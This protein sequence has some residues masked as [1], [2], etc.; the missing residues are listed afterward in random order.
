MTSRLPAAMAILAAI[1]TVASC[2]TSSGILLDLVQN[3]EGVDESTEPPDPPEEL[4]GLEIRTDPEGASVWINNRYQGTTP[5]VIDELPSGTYRVLITHDG[6][7]EQLVWLDYPGGPMRFQVTLDPVMG[8]VQIDVSPRDADVTL[9]GRR[10]SHG[11]SPV[12]IGSYDV[13]VS[14]FGYAQWNGRI[15]VWE[16]VVS[17]ISVDLEPSPFEILPPVLTR[18]VVNPEN[19]GLLGSVELRFDVTGPGSGTATIF[20][21]QGRSV[22]REDLPSFTSWSQRWT[23]RPPRELPD[24]GYSLVISGTGADGREAR[25]ETLFSLDRSLRIAPRSTWSGGAGLLYAPTA[26]VL[27]AGSFQASVTGLA[28]IDPSDW[29]L[30]APVVL[31]FRSG[32]GADLE[33]DASL[34]AIFTGSVLPVAGSVSL[35][36]Q[37]V[38]P[39]RPAGLGV[40]LE[41][42]AALQGVPGLGIL[43]TDTFANFSGV[44]LGVPL[45]FTTGPINLLFEPA[46]V[47]SAWQVDY[48]GPPV[49]TPSPASWMY[50]RAGLMIDTGAL[51]AGVS[52]SAR[53]LPLPGGLFTINL[54][55]QAAVE[56]TWLLPDTHVLVGAAVAGEFVPPPIGMYLMGGISLGLL[57]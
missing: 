19:P 54:P 44:S 24:G 34:S 38:E 14:A 3:A 15:E 30:Q 37:A 23:W 43:T 13:V 42:K 52:A 41:A 22:H 21:P 16:N 26:D 45:Q 11:I 36:W 7:Y 28:A 4:E 40:A 12:P 33:I 50:W 35:R 51:V 32:L 57:F 49:T 53:S 31:A 17:P 48:L 27:P 6:Y 20:D 47:F 25:R 9:D 55:V 18:A 8:Y 29:Q 39:A 10:V 56:V 1:L 2:A 46:I 5:L